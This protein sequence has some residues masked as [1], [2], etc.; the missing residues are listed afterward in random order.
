MDHYKLFIGGEFVEAADRGTWETLDPGTGEPIASVA[1]AGPADAEAAVECARKAFENS[2]WASMDPAQRS[3]IVMDFGDRLMVHAVRLAITESMDSG[4]II[5][6]TKT[7][8]FLGSMMVRNLAHLAATQFPWREEIPVSGNPFFPGRNYVRREPLGVCVG[9]V[10]WN[11]PLSM[12]LWKVTQAVVMGNSVILKPASNTPLSALIIAQAASESQIPPGIINVLPGPG[13]A[14]GQVLCSHPQVDKIAFTGSTLVGRQI[15]KL[16][17]DTVKKVTL[18]LGGKSANIIMDDADLDLAVDGGLFGTFFHSGQICESG[19][20]ILVQR[21][22]YDQ[23]VER[24]AAR[25]KELRIGYQLD[26]TVQMG[27]L[28]SAEQL[29]TTE[30]YVRLGREE[31]AQLVCG[32]RRPEGFGLEDGF[33]YEPT[34]FAQ[35]KNQMTIAQE[36]IFGPVVCVIPFDDDQEAIAIANDSIYGLGGG[37]WSRDTAR[38]ERLAAGV[39]TGTM[40]VNDYHMFGDFCPFGGYKQSGVGRELGLE[41]LSEYT[42]VKRVHVSAEGD[43]TNKLGFQMMFDYP[44]TSSFQFFG[45]TKVTAGPGARIALSTEAATLGCRRALVLSD[46][47]VQAAGLTDL[48]VKA[49]GDY[50]CG[51]FTDIPQDSSMDTVDA[52]AMEARRLGADMVVS[53]GGGSVMDTGKALAVLLKLGGRATDHV[54]VMRLTGPVCPHITVPTTAGTGSEVTHVAVIKNAAVKRKVY[55]LDPLIAPQVAILDPEMVIGLPAGLTASTAMDAL[56]HAVEAVSN[57]RANPLSDAHGLHAVRLIKQ[58]LPLALERPG[59]LKVRGDLQAAALMAGWSFCNAQVA[60]AHAMAHTIGAL[61]GVPHGVACG[62]LLPKVM[63]FNA[64]HASGPLS[65]VA[66]ALGL[67]IGGMDPVEAALAGAQAVEE[68][69]AQVGHP[70]KLSQV[71][72]PEEGLFDCSTHAVADPAVIFNPRPV[73]DPGLVYEVYEEAF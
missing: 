52:A 20:R 14:L 49:L 72:V 47:G 24:L 37:V 67:D 60:L 30:R 45:T 4:G 50:C 8:V 9:I 31:G 23:V 1:Q 43:R 27:P 36:E 32:G 69:M 12:A 13:G 51:V 22:I 34:I 35:V 18:E 15:M 48:A 29:A 5:N 17:A 33:F 61:Y 70:L 58:N 7:E 28:V 71:G 2:G 11:F 55:I 53:V 66:Q 21:G 54:A 10:P 68:L 64:E 3:R 16:G 25:V 42:Q 59:D 62:I 6:R 57:V 73:T 65:L 44:K 41:G 40:W 39:R 63:R 46:P 19:T 26:P 38:A 56:T